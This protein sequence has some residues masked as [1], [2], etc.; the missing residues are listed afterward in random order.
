V[1]WH[2][3]PPWAH[4]HHHLRNSLRCKSWNE[5]S[6][7][8]IMRP[9]A[10][11]TGEGQFP[12]EMLK[13][14]FLPQ[15]LS[16]T[17]V[18]EVFMHHFEKMSSAQTPPWELPLDLAGGLSSCRPPHCPTLEKILRGAHAYRVTWRRQRTARLWNS[19]PTYTAYNRRQ[20]V[21]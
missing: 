9:Q 18:N 3:K 12:L 6:G 14:V 4:H 19:R 8:L 2:D 1:F 13:S 10:L 21:Q 15:M 11:A 16:K 5:T 7:P 17:S 20:N